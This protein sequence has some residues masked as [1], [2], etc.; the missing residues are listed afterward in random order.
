[1]VGGSFKLRGNQ[2]TT[3][4]EGVL[5]A[6]FHLYFYANPIMPAVYILSH[7]SPLSLLCTFDLV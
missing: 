2:S 3:R 7:L 5:L 4:Y 1:M 6:G